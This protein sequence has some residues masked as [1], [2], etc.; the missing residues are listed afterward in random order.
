MWEVMGQEFTP[1][2]ADACMLDYINQK[3]NHTRYMI[4][5]IPDGYQSKAEVEHAFEEA[6]ERS[7]TKARRFQPNF[8]RY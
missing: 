8:L 4:P 1:E 6:Y 7:L 5:P 3:A 2:Q